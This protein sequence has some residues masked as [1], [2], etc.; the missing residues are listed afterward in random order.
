MTQEGGQPRHGLEIAP[1]QGLGVLDGDVVVAVE[2]AVL[3]D[4]DP[5]R[6]L[7]LVTVLLGQFIVVSSL[8]SLNVALPI[9]QTEFDA[10]PAALQ[11]LV[12]IYQISY[13]TVLAIG[14]RL[15][16]IF[17]RRRL[18]L[19]GIAGFALSSL[20]AALAPSIGVVV[21]CRLLQGIFGGLA[22]PQVLA[23]IQVA[24]PPR[25]RT[26]AFAVFGLIG[27]AG[28]VLGQF[29]S[30]AVIQLDLFGL[31]WRSA[32]YI[33]VVVGGLVVVA[34]SLVLREVN[35]TDSRRIDVGGMLLMSMASL[36]VLFPVIQGRE[37]GWPPF[38]IGIILLAGPMVAV[39]LRY[40][41]RVAA[42]GVQP[43]LN[44]AVLRLATFRH[45]VFAAALF[46]F[47]G[48]A[49]FFLLTLTLQLGF[50]LDPLQTAVATAPAPISA[51]IVAAFSARVIRRMGTRV[52]IVAGVL[53][54]LASTTLIVTLAQA[55]QPPSPLVLVPALVLLG[56]VGALA[57]PA[58]VTLTLSDVNDSSS[59]SASGMLQTAQQMVGALG[60]A[61][62]GSVFFAVLGPRVRADAYVEAVSWALVPSYFC[63][64]VL[65]FV[66]FR[67]RHHRFGDR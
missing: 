67:F 27:A 49:P 15:G 43:L 16:D 23:M 40:E 12:V 30:G 55:A 28:F 54:A 57:N 58:A 8:G 44:P 37:A 24:F 38:Y 62:F 64:A 22:S 29:I 14:G 7:I 59:A 1:A 61:V 17:G 56:S 3:A 20:I 39:L 4:G 19:L 66:G 45:G 31:S 25:E 18:F 65:M 32:F 21:A 34:A 52:F 53:N 35:L 46:G 42:A 47:M 60:V 5:R 41:R 2:G 51:V 9:I 10:S 6:W 50:G 48:F 26:T 13:A 11:W 63:A 33:N 36:M